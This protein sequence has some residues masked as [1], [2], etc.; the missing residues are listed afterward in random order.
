[1]RSKLSKLFLGLIILGLLP[2]CLTNKAFAT[3]LTATIVVSDD[4][5]TPGQ[6]SLVTITFSEAVTGFDLSDLAVGGSCTLNGLY[7]SNNINYT[8]TLTPPH[9]KLSGPFNIMLNY[10]S[11]NIAGVAGSGTTVSNN[12]FVDTIAPSVISV[13]VP[14]GGTYGA[15]ANLDFIVNMDEP[16]VVDTNGGFPSIALVVGT[17]TVYA[18][19]V[20]GSGTN[21]LT[22]RYTV[23][24]PQSD[25]NGITIGALSLNGG[26]IQ[27]AIGVD[28]ILTLNSVGSTA[29]VNINSSI[30]GKPPEI[31]GVGVPNAATYKAG[32][33]LLF[34]INTDEPVVVFGT[35]YID[36]VIGASVVQADYI[37]GSGTNALL[38]RYTVQTGQFDSNGIAIGALSLN[39][40][41]IKDAAG[42]DAILTL[43]N[44]G[45][46]VGVK[47][48]AI[49]PTVVLSSTASGT[50]N[51]AFLISITFSEAV[52][53]FASGNIIVGNGT[54]SN[55]VAT[56]TT[57][58]TA[59]INPTTSGQAVTVTVTANAATD[60]AGN[61]NTA[62]NTI[63]FM[64]DTTKPVVTFG[65][66]TANQ[67]FI[68]P[69]TSVT[70]SV[71][72]AVYWVAGGAQLTSSNA[73]P[74][75]SME[76][77][78]VAFSTYTASYDEPART[79]TLTFNGTL[80]DG[81]YEVKV[82]GDVV[83]NVNGNTLDA[84]NASF[85]VAAPKITGIS[86]N[87]TSFTSSGG[88]TTATITGVNL[89]GQ[90]VKV[91]I[92]G[93]EASTAII[94]SATSSAA[95]VTIP[96]N[97]STSTKIHNLTV[98]LNGIV[99]AGQSAT[100][101]VSGSS[102]II[103]DGGS[104]T[105]IVM[106]PIIDQNGITLDPDKIDTTKPSVTLEV[107]PKD[108]VAYVKIPAS[109][110]TSFEGKNATFFIEIKTPYGS[111]QV[112]VN[113]ASIIPGLKDLLSANNLKAE[114]I[115]FKIA[116]TDKSGDK[117]IQAA[118]ATGLPKGKVLGAIVDF[119]IDIINTKTGQPIGTADQF[120]K[121]LTRVIPMSKNT[122]NMPA[123]WGAFRYNETSMN[124]EFVPAKKVQIDGVWYV[125][126]SS[127]S[128]S[129]YV[130][131]D[132]AASFTD[133]QRHWGK[134]DVQLAAAKGLVEGVGNGKYD[135]NRTV[136]RA[137]FAAMLVRALGRGTSTGSTAP[138]DDVKI[139]AWYFGDVA[140]AKELG[141]L[142]FVSGTNF[143]PDQPLTRE[144]MA[145]MLAVVT[146]LDKLPTTKEWVSLDG[147]K[148]IG[149]VDAIYLEDVRLMVKLN[150]M[151]GTGAD[152]FSPKG[153]TT[154]AQ[155]AAVFIRTLQALEM[156][157]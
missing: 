34:T 46:T 54:V 1:M 44:A 110:L 100:V 114:D 93:A 99:V 157:D 134:T 57:T 9:S 61:R 90:T 40:G 2:L 132:N 131:A 5:L 107:T 82:A 112:P 79:Y 109:I 104:P 24:T 68:A 71:S 148:D 78:S 139:G 55:L 137:E 8:A 4:I 69:P 102:G 20:S 105:P 97:A 28:A 106:P 29:G 151:T 152:T 50:V 113:L 59:T 101:K 88:S 149:S 73:L 66:F 35:P 124:F 18:T 136:T 19:Y 63:S 111:Y 62:S 13:S 153:Q 89:T 77:D 103:Y 12:Y 22:F 58:Y 10:A 75:V 42:N 86:V 126:I 98:D 16:V 15:G 127:Y 81:T 31:N 45:S 142:D 39:G 38:F 52:S 145:S 115:S 118:V 144:E 135:P 120:S 49:A 94:N 108:G 51:A 117:D 37:S 72:E 26:M 56:N 129:V 23:Q 83:E 25:S 156:I 21:A 87:P 154:R 53:G 30:D 48:D 6:T 95:T 143:K 119:H 3:P 7:T 41:S 116:L 60:A 123:Q 65:G 140:K 84:A 147:Y 64:Y 133:I 70:V 138:Y 130:V 43:N 122:V 128:N 11:V 96:Q 14:A 92:D 74:L 80:A 27:D 33:T 91:Y 150:I 67:T 141:L 85:T 146:T 125:M 121:A 76:K 36:L 155:A 17:Q 32:D 47:I